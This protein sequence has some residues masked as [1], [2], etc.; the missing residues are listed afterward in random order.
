[1]NESGSMDSRLAVLCKKL[2][3][4]RTEVNAP[5]RERVISEE[6]LDECKRIVFGKLYS[7]GNINFQA[8]LTTMKKAWKVNSVNLAHRESGILSFTFDSETDKERVLANSPWSFVSNLLIL[9]PWESNKP[10]QCYKFTRCAFWV[11]IHGLPIEWCC[12][13]VV[14]HIAQTLGCVKEAKVEKKGVTF[15]KVG[16]ARV[17]LDLDT[18][19]RPGILYNLEEEK[20]WLDFKYERLPRFCY[21]CGRVGHFATTCEEV[22]FD[23]AKYK[24]RKTHRFG[25]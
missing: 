7:G 9:Q 16:Q 25:H 13:E 4:L 17:E 21:S 18:P 6:M 3:N 14:S 5:P 12:E 8:F 22:P 23:M 20:V 19:L 1:M 15:Q 2:G 10:A 24:D 11:Q